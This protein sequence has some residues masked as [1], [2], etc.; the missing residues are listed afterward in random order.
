MFQEAPSGPERS[1]WQP[2]PAARER[3]DHLMQFYRQ[4]VAALLAPIVQSYN[5]RLASDGGLEYRKMLEL[6]TKMTLV[7]HACTEIADHPFDER[8]EAIAGL[9]GACCFL[10]DSFLDD[11]GE[12]ATREYL[13]RFELLFTSGWFEVRNDREQLFYVIIAR[14]FAERNI[15]EP[16]LRQSLLRLFEAQR[17]DVDMRYSPARLQ[18]LPRRQF[19]QL[20]KNCARDRSG[21]A[22]ILLSAFLVP[23]MS[24]QYMRL[25]FAAGALIMFIDDHGDSFADLADGRITYMNQLARPRQALRRIFHSQV[26]RL[27]RGLPFGDGRDLLIAFLTRYY[28]TRLEKYRQQRRRG[29]SAWAVYE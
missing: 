8:R 14:L 13:G 15:L 10:A 25:M 26:D 1:G 6:S 5:P 23:G 3:V 21:H 17:R 24:L 11:F 22:I 20:L 12:A 16:T 7:G 4:R 18:A 29:A 19:L 28:L 2:R 9:F 27:T